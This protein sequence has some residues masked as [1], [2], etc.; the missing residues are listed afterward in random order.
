[1]KRNIVF[2]INVDWYFQLHWVERALYFKNKGFNVHVISNFKKDGIQSKLI[3]DGFICHQI[4]LKRN[5]LNVMNEIQTVINVKKLISSIKPELIHCITVKPNVYMGILNSFIFRTPIIYSITGLGAAFSSNT[6]KFRC[7]KV[8][9]V[10]LYRL[11]S[12]DKSMFIFENS[13]DYE[14]FSRL[15]ILKYNNGIVIKGAGVDIKHFH[16][17]KPPENRI[18]LFAARLLADKGL[19]ELIE[20]KRLLARDNI[21]FVLN[22]AGIIDDDVSDAIPLRKI[23]EWAEKNE[24]NWLGNVSKMNRLISDSDIVCLPTSYG[25]GVPRILIEA[26]SSQRAIITTS[27]PG[28]REI[29]I[30]GY[31]GLLVAPKNIDKLASALKKLLADNYL[32]YSFGLNGRILVE[33]EFTQEVVIEKTNEVYQYLLSK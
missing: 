21:N 24:I 22:V 12:I 26:A 11:I 4:D 33:R 29:V 3:L 32:S 18:V 14:Q 13:E 25:E 9:I 16:P 19:Y 30:D 5:S 17:S 2:F 10:N 7:L 28:C 23:E 15:G 27:V 1:M 31:N 20:A 8:A 6:L